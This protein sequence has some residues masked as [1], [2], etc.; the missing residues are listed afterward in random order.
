LSAHRQV[1]DTFSM[2]NNNG[3]EKPNALVVLP[4]NIPAELKERNQWVVWRYERTAKGWTKPPFNAHTRR[5]ASSTNSDTWSPFAVALAVYQRGGWD[6]IGYVLTADDPYTGGDLDRCRDPATGEL[7]PWAENVLADLGDGYAE[8]SPSA[9]GLRVIV[10]AVKPAGDCNAAQPA[11]G[12]LEIYDRER[13]LTIT[14]QRLPF[15]AVAIPER[16][17]QLDAVYRRFILG[18]KTDGFES[19]DEFAAA[20]RPQ[21]RDPAW[22]KPPAERTPE[23]VVRLAA[24]AR[25]GAKFRA[26]W[27]GDTGLFDGDHSRADAALCRILAHWCL[28]NPRNVDFLFRR[29]GLMRPKWDERRGNSTYGAREVAR[30]CQAAAGADQLSTVGRKVP[31]RPLPPYR[32]FPVDLLPPVVCDLVTAGAESIGCDPALVAI[33]ALAAVAGCVGNS[34]AVVLK[35]GWSEPAVVWSLTVAESGGHKSPSFY[36]AVGPVLDLQADRFDQYREKKAAYKKDREDFKQQKDPKTPP[37]EPKEPSRF[38]TTNSTVEALGELLRE[39]VHGMLYARDELDAWFQSFTQ[40]R[41]KGTDRPQWLEM[42][43]A[44][45]L[46]VDRITR[47]EKFLS[48]RRAAVSLTGTIQPSVLAAALTPD[49][50]QAGLGGRFLL[51]MPPRRKRVWTEADVPEHVAAAYR[52]LLEGLLALSL[53]DAAKRTPHF[54]GLSHGA[55][56]L[57]VDFFN[58]WGE[59]QHAAEGEQRSAFAKIEGYAPRL[60]LLHHVVTEVASRVPQEPAQAGGEV[61]PELDQLGAAGYRPPPITEASMAAGIEL[62]RWFAGEALRIYAVL[63]ESEDERQRRKLVEW[64]AEQGGRVTVRHLQRSNSRRWPASGPAEADLQALVAAGLGRWEEGVAPRGGNPGR[65]FQLTRPTLDSCC[66][67]GGDVADNCQVSDG[68]GDSYEGPLE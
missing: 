31:Y 47:D 30:A 55:K 48:V 27:E 44:G 34:R 40:Y 51:A 67:P 66:D 3:L 65:W 63:R 12:K 10:R 28:G 56:A 39:N 6:G 15:S 58:E 60:A 20:Y 45:T 14:G 38:V 21:G 46:L 19:L 68:H 62:A 9:A 17:A 54:L 1:G 42:H 23:E 36:K 24:Q 32:P 50:L 59:V 22:D 33:P 43:K 4:E 5:K 64:I 25:N 29:S 49:A 37:T 53:A 11:G 18:Q 2:S 8:P 16:Q 13:Y 52:R 61:Y 35:S 41:S 7:R 57:W 26:L